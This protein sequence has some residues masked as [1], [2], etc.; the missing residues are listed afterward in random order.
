MLLSLFAKVAGVCNNLEQ[1]KCE[2]PYLNAKK[3]NW[4]KRNS[5]DFFSR[6]LIILLASEGIQV[7]ESQ[8]VLCNESE[9]QY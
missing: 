6:E 9:Y 8:S 3:L 5:R 1:S 4:Y 7:I 2:L